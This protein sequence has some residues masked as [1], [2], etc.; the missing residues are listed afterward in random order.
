MLIVNTC[1]AFPLPRDRSRDRDVLAR[2]KEA[3]PT[4]VVGRA[5]FCFYP[6]HFQGRR[7]KE[8]NNEG[9]KARGV[10]SPG[11]VGTKMSYVNQMLGNVS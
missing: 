2:E 11:L 6:R 5:R 3:D 10:L 9:T 8:G 7:K 1:N 4:F